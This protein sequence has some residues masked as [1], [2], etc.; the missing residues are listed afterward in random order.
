MKGPMDEADREGS[1]KRMASAAAKR[2][3]PLGKALGRIQYF[4]TQRGIAR[5][6][7]EEGEVVTGS[8][9]PPAPVR[10]RMGA[11]R[12]AAPAADTAARRIKYAPAFAT[13]T[14]L[15]PGLAGAV[16][17]PVWREIG[18]RL[19]PR[20]QTYGKGGNNKPSV[21]GRCSGVVVDRFDRRKLTL[22]TAGGGIWRSEDGGATWR[23]LT[24]QM[25]TTAM[26]AICAAPSS[27]NIVYAG[28]GEGDIRSP[29][30]VGLLRSIDGGATWEHLPARELT[31]T[32]IYDIAVDPAD[33]LHVWVGAVA[34]LF[35][36]RDGGQSWRALR[37]GLTWDISINP[38]QPGEVLV[39]CDAGLLRSTNGGST[40]SQVA[41]P[42]APPGT[43]FHRLEVCHAPSNG[44][45]AYVA[46]AVG[47]SPLLW[48][49]ATAGGAFAAETAPA[50]MDVTQAWYD[51]CFAVSPADP[52]LVIWGAIELFRGRRSGAGGWSW[53]NIA[54]RSSGDSIHPDMHDV[55]FD[56]TDP[57]TLYCCNDGGLYRSP[58][59]GT[60]WESLNPGLGIT[61]FEFLA[62]LE[63]QDGWLM[64]GTQD[65]GTLA[66]GAPPTWNQ[67]ALGDG[68]DCGATEDAG[69]TCFH[70]YY[71]MWIERAPALGA[72]A[73]R[74]T[75]V[76]PSFDDSYD[77]LF[78]PPMDVQGRVVA[79]AGQSIF[80]SADL[81]ASWAEVQ[82]P[83]V[84]GE[85]VSA[86]AIANASTI[87]VGTTAGAVLRVAKGAGGWRT[88]TVTA[89]RRPR[90]GYVSDI[91]VVGTAMRTLWVSYSS[92]GAG[93][94]FRSTNGGSSWAN[95]S[96]NLP[97]I[98]INALVVDPKNT[99]RV[100]AASDHGVYRTQDSGVRWIDFSNGLPNV[101]VGDLILHERRRV[102]LAGTRNRG[103]WE[104][105]I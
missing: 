7:V 98:P 9:T 8:S 88:A 89:L 100:F 14:R 33:A 70:S 45:I 36:S 83:R 48:R 79:K 13:K 3:N 40:W 102:L 41:L 91:V 5:T 76:S 64:G 1:V 84:Q 69:R 49:R 59:S 15:A 4:E 55:G 11:S 54:S 78:Y 97:D 47:N 51:W 10:G 81:G 92:F 18:P 62:N 19:I 85:L 50:R 75:D 39:A 20:G 35:E 58:D 101:V 6:R 46:G 63:S 23:P 71:G 43:R 29:L 94:V 30:G 66:I 90:A 60:K 95:R 87:F 53:E 72:G 73:F 52:S 25:P 96:G 61:E 26:G 74:W 99:R 22:C 12:R 67:I 82:F 17:L 57:A 24:D 28:T 103:A 32:G 42:G 38:T 34:G 16:G 80:V 31:G 105:D 21:S 56:P 77:A 2:R 104:V 86:L 27:P 93:H 68:G 65:N 44:A 37:A